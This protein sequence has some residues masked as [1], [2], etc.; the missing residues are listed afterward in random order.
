MQSSFL[1]VPPLRE[2]AY[3]VYHDESGTDREHDRF[4]FQGALFVPEPRS[5]E[6]LGLLADARGE[7]RGR[8]HFVDLRDKARSPKAE[9]TWNWINLYFNTL[10]HFCPFK[11][12]VADTASA[13]PLIARFSE[14]HRLYN[15][16]AM[17]AVRSALP[18]S[19]RE[20]D[21][22]HMRIFS[23]STSRSPDDNF[24]TYLPRQVA[25]TANSPRPRRPKCPRIAEPVSPVTLVEGDP[26]KVS[27]KDA[28]HC[29]FIQLADL[30]TSAVAQAVNASGQQS[31]KLELASLVAGW[32]EDTRL[33]PWSQA[34]DLHRRFSVSCFP[35]A[36]GG[37][38]EVD[39]SVSRRGQ[40]PLLP[41]G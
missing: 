29:E 18:W 26:S 31:I 35:G 9:V 33:P 19:F 30:L 28:G 21:L 8:I 24:A 34:L 2:A 13:H 7:Y 37:F 25:R 14:P 5:H 6:A 40:L 39:L 22:L 11:C 17:M 23:E 10:S 27:S 41:G 1:G 3:S 12:M 15:Y 36:S 32:I 4:L 38:F 20:F 16:T